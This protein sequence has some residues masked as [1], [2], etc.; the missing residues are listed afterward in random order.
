M[1]VVHRASP[2]IHRDLPFL[3]L[4]LAC[5]I[6]WMGITLRRAHTRNPLTVRYSA[7]GDA[8]RTKG[9]G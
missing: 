3:P 9:R 1:L 6:C 7:T 5:R 4:S 2:G 8:V